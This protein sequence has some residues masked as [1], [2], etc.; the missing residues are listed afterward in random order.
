VVGAARQTWATDEIDQLVANSAD[1]PVCAVRGELV[2]ESTLGV[3]GA[4]VWLTGKS[5]WPTTV[6]LNGSATC[7]PQAEHIG[8]Q[9]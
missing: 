1:P 6:Y 8:W 7:L 4:V 9:L 3:T 2:V 5:R